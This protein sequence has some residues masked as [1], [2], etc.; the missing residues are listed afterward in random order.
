MRSPSNLNPVSSTSTHNDG[1]G[2][3]RLRLNRAER[4]VQIATVCAERIA[5]EGYSHTS[6]RDVAAGAG[7]STGTLLH[8]FESKEKMLAAT[9]LLVS[10]DFLA[11]IREAGSGDDDAVVRLR[12][13]VRAVLDLDR[14]SIGWRVWIAFWHEASINP[15]LAVVAGERTGLAEAIFVD[16]IADARDAGLLDV[17]DPEVSA[18]ELAALIDGVALRMC[19]EAGRWSQERAIGLVERLIDDWKP[20]PTVDRRLEPTLGADGLTTWD[21][22]QYY[23]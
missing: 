8:H 6:V 23:R 14:H 7:I 5:T 19:S 22:V 1:D 9:L 11:H 18:G 13:V 21:S 3:P 16:L 10:D 15:E 20:R 4:R 17:D 2:E 12:A